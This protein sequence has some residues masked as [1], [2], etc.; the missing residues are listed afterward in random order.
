[1]F[2]MRPDVRQQKPQQCYEQAC[3]GKCE[4]LGMEEATRVC[5]MAEAEEGLGGFLVQPTCPPLEMPVILQYRRH[6]NM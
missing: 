1:M 3:V 2:R 5:E 4:Y 6:K